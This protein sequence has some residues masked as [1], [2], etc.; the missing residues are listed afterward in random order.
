MW[1]K[2]HIF[3]ANQHGFTINL[4]GNTV[5]HADE[6][7]KLNIG[8]VTT[9]LPSWATKV[10]KTPAGNRLLICPA[11]SKEDMTCVKCGL[12]AK[13]P[14]KQIIAFPAHG[15]RKNCL[16]RFIRLMED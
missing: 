13:Y 2:Q 6:L 16:D 12:C 11:V 4:S 7:F 5:E 15:T 10:S 8:P 9:H 1:N 14:R 3:Y